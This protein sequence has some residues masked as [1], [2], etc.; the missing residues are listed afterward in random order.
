M[1]AIVSLSASLRPRLG[2]AAGA[3]VKP[4]DIVAHDDKDVGHSGT[5][6]TPG[7][8]ATKNA[9]SRIEGDRAHRIA[10]LKHAHEERAAFAVFPVFTAPHQG[11]REAACSL[12]DGMSVLS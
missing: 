10:A 9:M 5:G 3:N 4:S 2:F 12:N 1:G 8:D 11:E 7:I 6:K